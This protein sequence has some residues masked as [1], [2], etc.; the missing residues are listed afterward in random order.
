MLILAVLMSFSA[1]DKPIILRHPRPAAKYRIT[2]D[3]PCGEDGNYVFVVEHDGRTSQLTVSTL[4]GEPVELKS[5][6]ISMRDEVARL[7]AVWLQ[8][9]TCLYGAGA[10][11]VVHGVEPDSSSTHGKGVRLPFRADL[12]SR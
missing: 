3:L 10:L 7:K 1:Q 6:A 5:D 11:V 2:T 9:V 8:P 4:N 12:K